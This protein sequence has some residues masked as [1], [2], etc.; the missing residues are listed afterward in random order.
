MAQ[1]PRQYKEGIIMLLTLAS[2][3]TKG[4]ELIK[5]LTLTSI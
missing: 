1:Y 4:L 3:R 2:V 5:E